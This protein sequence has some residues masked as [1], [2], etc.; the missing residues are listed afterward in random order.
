MGINGKVTVSVYT[1][2]PDEQYLIVIEPVCDID[3]I[4]FEF[5][6]EKLE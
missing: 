5:L 2:S 1:M 4:S 6:S 3:F